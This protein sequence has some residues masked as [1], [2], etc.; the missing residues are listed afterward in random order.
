MGESQEDGLKS[1]LIKL[2][3]DFKEEMDKSL[4]EIWENIIKQV[5]ELNKTIQDLK[6]EIK[7]VRKRQTEGIL[8][9]ENLG[10]RI[11]TTDSSITN[12]I[13]EREERYQEQKI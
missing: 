5:Q 8:Q 4:K 1:N 12:R 6:M 2:I 13:Q 10:K 7:V 3:K 9:V 11:G